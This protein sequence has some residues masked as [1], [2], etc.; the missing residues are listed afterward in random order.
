MKG[1][2]RFS[3]NKDKGRFLLH[4]MAVVPVGQQ[5]EQSLPVEY[6]YGKKGKP[7]EVFLL[8]RFYRNDRNIAE[9]FA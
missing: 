3:Q 8:S 1:H 7:S 5:L 2:P 4:G 6:F 9:A